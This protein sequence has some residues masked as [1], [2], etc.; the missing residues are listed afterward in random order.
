MD[1]KDKIE[2]ELVRLEENLE[3]YNAFVNN[4]GSPEDDRKVVAFKL[5][6]DMVAF[7]TL[8]DLTGYTP[9]ENTIRH[10]LAGGFREVVKYVNVVDGKVEI[11]PE[12]RELLKM[13]NDFMKTK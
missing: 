9:K 13:K 2:A 10:Q 4:P 12:Y 8:A 6:Y 11:S 7:T 1:L 5:F 3:T